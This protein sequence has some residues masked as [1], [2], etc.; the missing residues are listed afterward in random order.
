MSVIRNGYKIPFIDFPPP[1]VFP[2]NPSALKEKDFVSEAISDL[3][4]TR[5]VEVLDYPPAIVNPLPVSNQSSGK[6]TLILDLRHV[7]LYIFNQKF[8]CEDLKVALKVLSKGFYLFKFDL[9]S[10]YHH[11]EIF[12][13]H[14]SFLAFSWDFGN[15][16][17]K[18]FQ[19]AVLPFGLSSAPYL[20]TKLLRPAITSWRCK[21]I[22]M[23]IFLHDGLGGGASKMKAKINSLTVHA[24]LLNFGFVFN[25]EKSIWEP[26]QII[27]WLGTVLDTNQG[28]ISV[29][30]ER[31]SKLKVNVDSVLKGDSMFVNVKSLATVV[32]Q[33]I[34]LTPCV[35]GVARIMTR[36]LYAVVNPKVSWKCIVV[37]TKESC[38][39]LVLWSQS[40]N[41]LNCRCP[42]LP[43]CQPAKLLYSDASHYACGSF[44]HSKGK[45]F[46]Q[47]WSPVE[48]N[49]SSAWRELKAVELALISLLLVF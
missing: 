22:P 17:L 39:E 24:D 19:F 33:I 12:P 10:D 46:Q 35:G 38:S 13:D 25:E 23:A 4:V 21:G 36:S 16:I 45:L 14:R 6:K 15:G 31:I 20:F 5:R 32:G 1:K 34:L 26:V 11:V 27:T 29:T 44:I 18:H 41:F 47:N 2:N 7:N 37:L 9:K 3:L 48:R 42:W 40:A 30:E 43:L 28:F 8:K 49:N